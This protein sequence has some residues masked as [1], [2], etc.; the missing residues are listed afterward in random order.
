MN[1]QN[2]YGNAGTVC[3]LRKALGLDRFPQ[4]VILHGPPGAGKYTLAQML[5]RC[6]NC[7][8]QAMSDGLP[9]FCGKCSNCLRIAQADDFEDRFAEAVEARE[10]MRDADKKDTR[11]VIQ[12]HPDVMIVP[13][14]PPQMLIK[15]G[16]VRRV[17]STVPYHPESGR[18]KIFIFTES[19]FMKEAVNALLKVLEEPPPYATF[20]LLTSNPSELPITIQSRC[21]KFLLAPLPAAE[22]EAYLAQQRPEW[23]PK[24][25][26]LVS[27]LSG[28]AVGRAYGFDIESYVTARQDALLLLQSAMQN[29]SDGRVTGHSQ[30]FQ[31]TEGYR[32]GADGKSK[33][34][35][36]LRT[37]YSVLE[38]LLF[39]QSGTPEMI[40]NTDIRP[41][42]EKMAERTDF[43]WV[44]AAAAGLGQVERGM[45]R[46]LLRDLSLDAFATSLER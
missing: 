37:L 28:G 14:D 24:Q 8:I 12:T 25:R 42:L 11:I 45:R 17:I 22:I 32:G 18:R 31:L 2:F 29:S 5:A 1:F 41:A 3:N 30:L 38:D 16:Q 39:V 19:A 15:V 46:N 7:E 34:D 20:F 27:R 35:Q 6:M 26:A 43:A 21:I 13:P 10:N 40:R 36:L 23:S 9:D 33:T 44:Q 4:A